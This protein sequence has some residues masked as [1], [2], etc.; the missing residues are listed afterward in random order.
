MAVFDVI[1]DHDR[2]PSLHS[3]VS[4]WRN[5]EVVRGVTK[6]GVGNHIRCFRMALHLCCTAGVNFGTLHTP[7]H[8]CDPSSDVS[9]RALAVD[10]LT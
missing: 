5:Q 7:V 10:V 6:T 8:I 2:R 1:S 3:C 4:S 9:W